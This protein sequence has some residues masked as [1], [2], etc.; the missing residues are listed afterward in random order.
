MA[1]TVAPG[2][3]ISDPVEPPR[4]NL[5]SGPGLLFALSMLG[6]AGLVSNV[7]IGATQG[8]RLLWVLALVLALRFVWL[9]TSARYVL[10]TGESLLSGFGR[11]GRWIPWSV[12]ASLLVS[13]HLSNL[14]KVLLMGAAAQILLPL[15]GQW[16]TVVW[17]L[18]FVT[19][20]FVLMT[21]R[22]KTLDRWCRP[23]IASMGFALTIATALSHP[24][25]PALMRGLFL[26]LIGGGNGGY[27]AVLLITALIGAEAGAVDNASYTY[28]LSQRGWAVNSFL[29]R[30]RL[31]LLMS[32]GCVFAMDAMLQIAAA[33]TLLPAHLVPHKAEDLIPVFSA[34]LGVAGRIIF[35][36]GLWAVCFSGFVAG[37]TGSSLIAADIWG[38]SRPFKH[39]RDQ[40]RTGQPP[41]GK[42]AKTRFYLI[43]FWCFSPL[44]ILLTHVQP[45]WLVL[46]VSSLKALLIPG[47]AIALLVISND[48]QRLGEYRNG[49]FTNAALGLLI[50]STLYFSVRNA[51]ELIHRL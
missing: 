31:D 32:L 40:A 1:S 6:P 10:V 34:A 8:Y 33:G 16:G 2:S 46:V 36:F 38:S 23:M 22:V 14:Y 51:V 29:R 41:D 13:R 17:S 50:L 37:T 49:P 35:A 25:F 5:F 39:Q 45:V 9:S 43:A 26:P 21:R 30:Q 42:S 28:F 11:L 7:T 18:I 4:R 3:V 15:P 12:L 47:M 48:R 19:A 24:D 27:G 20:G 44:Y